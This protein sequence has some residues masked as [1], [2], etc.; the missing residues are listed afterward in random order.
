MYIPVNPGN[1]GGPVMDEKGNVI[2]VITGKQ[3]QTSGV[4]F[5]VKSNYLLKAIQS[6][7]ADS[8]SKSL[9]LSTKNTLASLSRTQ[10]IKKLRNYV[11]M[12]K[13]YNQ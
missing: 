9:N 1:S 10:Q 11:F 12:V 6:I 8:L 4:A 7:P 5:A 13:V 2:G 3:T